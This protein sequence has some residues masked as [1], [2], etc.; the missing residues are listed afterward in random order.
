MPT[1]PLDQRAFAPASPTRPGPSSLDLELSDIDHRRLGTTLLL[2][3]GMPEDS[4]FRARW[5]AMADEIRSR[6]KPRKPRRWAPRFST[7]A[8]IEW[9]RKQGWTLV[10]RERFVSRGPWGHGH[11]DL[12]GG[13][14]ACF[15]DREG[16]RVFVQGAGRGER[17]D[18]RARFDARIG[19]LA[20]G[21]RFVYV[22]FLR[23]RRDPVLVEWWR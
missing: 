6:A 18:H 22:E 15:I 23:G 9:G 10:D 14:D 7:D 20:R 11:E 1:T 4:P 13:S 3:A 8:A 21:E 12:A 19:Q 2:L 16:C 17:P 5:E